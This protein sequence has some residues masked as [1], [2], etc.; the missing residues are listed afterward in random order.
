MNHSVCPAI[1]PKGSFF[2]VEDGVI[3]NKRETK[4][5]KGNKQ[6]SDHSTRANNQ[7]QFPHDTKIYQTK[8]KAHYKNSEKQ[9]ERTSSSWLRLTRSVE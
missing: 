7:Q 9:L 4:N 8:F 6:D 2:G 3:T 5:S 1:E